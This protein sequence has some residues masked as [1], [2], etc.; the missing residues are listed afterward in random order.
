MKRKLA[1]F[2][3][4]FAGAEWFAAYVPPLVLVPAAAL[5]LLVL[6]LCWRRTVRPPLLGAAAGLACFAAFSLLAVAPVQR[7]A[8]QNV[9][10]TVTV[11]TDAQ[12]SFQEGRLRG[13]LRVEELNGRAVNFRVSCSAFP[14]RQPGERFT[15]RFALLPLEQDRYRMNT[16]SDGVFLQAEYQGDYTPL[17]DSTAFRFKL[18]RLRQDWAAR[19]QRWLPSELGK[20]EAALL[21][22]E[23]TALGDTVQDTFR[24]AGVSHLL[25]VSGLHVA[26]LC[27]VFAPG[28]RRR[29][30]RPLIALRA[31]VVL[32]YMLLTGLPVS[33]QRAGLVFLL[34]LAGDFFLQP[35][36]LLTSTGAV[37]ILLSLQ[38]AYT[39]CD[40]GFQLSFCAVLGVQGAGALTRWEEQRLCPGDPK[41]LRLYRLRRVL[42]R[43]AGDVQVAVLATLA[44]L[45]VLIA[46]GMTASGVG[47]LTNLLVV[48]MLRYL[49]LLGL[50]VLVL[51]ALPLLAPLMHMASLIL[52]VWLQVL[53]TLVSW[54]AA[55]PAAQIYLPPRY[56]LLAL[57]VLGALAVVFWLARRLVWY[58]PVAL[59]CVAAA[60]AFGVAAQQ[61]V[62]TLALVGT[63]N[64]PCLVCLQNGQTLVLFRGGESNLRAVQEYLAARGGQQIDLLVDLRQEPGPLSFGAAEVWEM[65]QADIP[66]CRQPA[67]DGAELDLYHRSSGNLAVLGIGDRHI[68]VMAGRIQLETPLQ[69]DVFCAAGALSPSVQSPVILCSTRNPAWRDQV[70]GQTVWYGAEEPAV[71]L[72]PGR[73]MI[74]EEVERLALQ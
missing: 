47:V 12:T 56:T 4:G 43:V 6:F 45:P 2:G 41:K 65:E 15:A 14:A 33:V 68:A 42:L 34:A 22:G 36:D 69:V 39:P 38:N 27:G 17:A 32:F 21:L 1:W 13:T 66:Y 20:L 18:F 59:V 63:A 70:E 57:A 8:G 28:K 7:L 11:E 51:S 64:N 49:L 73:S 25:A 62:A 40:V 60:F 46:H 74:F 44:T 52:A 35:V 30:L 67:L 9:T 55:L 48:W 54:C 72:R 71:V 53:V 3:L 23:R 58:L 61:N 16:L 10:C 26:L 24:A 29:F 5:L 31:A 37:A 50:L 19:L